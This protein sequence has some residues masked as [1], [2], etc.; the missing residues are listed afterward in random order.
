MKYGQLEKQAKEI[1]NMV[2]KIT[3]EKSMPV[4]HKRADL[5]SLKEFSVVK[6]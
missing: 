1:Q 2:R 6:K 4:L 3:H 5:V